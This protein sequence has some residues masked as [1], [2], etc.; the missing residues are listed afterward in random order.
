[1]KTKIE[2]KLQH[3]EQQAKQQGSISDE[4]IRLFMVALK[5]FL[6]ARIALSQALMNYD[7]PD[8]TLADLRQLATE[9]LSPYPEAQR[10]FMLAWQEASQCHKS[11][12]PTP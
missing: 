2:Q 11:T 5:P 6:E 7:K 8:C 10:A 4:A 1:M 12:A 9:H 3:L